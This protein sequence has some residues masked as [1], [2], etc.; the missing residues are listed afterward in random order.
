MAYELRDFVDIITAVREE[1]SIQASDTSAINRIKRDI[2]SVYIHEVIGENRW[3]W[4]EKATTLRVPAVYMG[5][6]VSVLAEED[7]VTLSDNPPTTLGSF[8]GFNFSIEGEAEIYEIT[9]HTAGDTALEISPA[10][11]GAAKPEAAFKIWKSEFSL[12]ADLRETIEIR[13]DFAIHPLEG[14]G[15][16]EFHRILQ[17]GQKTEG[18]PLYYYTGN[19]LG[20]VDETRVRRLRLFPAILNASTNVKISYVEKVEPLELDADEPKIPMQDRII[21][22]YGALVRQSMKAKDN[23]A[24]TLY[25]AKFDR[26]LAQMLGKKEDTFDKPALEPDSLYMR[27]KRGS[28]AGRLKSS[29]NMI[30]STG[31]GASA[32]IKFLSDVTISGGTLTANLAVTPGTTID[33]RDVSEDGAALDA[34]IAGTSGV[35][36]ASGSVVGTT[37]AQ[38]LINKTIDADANTISNLEHGAE[39]DDPSSGVHGVTGSVVGTTDTQ[40]LTGKTIV[41][42]DNTITTAA[43]GNLSA[44]E[45]DA[46]LQELQEDIDTRALDSD[47]TNHMSDTSTHGVGEIV[48]TTETQTLTNKT[49]QGA[50]LTGSVSGAITT[51]AATTGANQ[52]LSTP[53]TAIIRLTNASLES[54][55]GLTAPATAQFA[56]LTNATGNPIELLDETGSTAANQI[57]TGSGLDLR[58]ANAS[59]AWLYYDLTSARWR[60]V[61][62]SGGGARSV[63]GTTSS[64]IAI[65]AAGGITAVQ[66]ADEDLYLESDGGFV[67][68]TADPQI[69]AGNVAGQTLRLIGA[70]NTDAIRLEDGDGL[71]LN[72]SWDSVAGAVLSLLWDEDSTLWR[73]VSRSN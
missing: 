60:V 13:H 51:D 21:L 53:A 28:S 8:V 7:T 52:T 36:G 48:G 62:G 15:L 23:E 40:T 43:V 9:A 41:V 47:L 46:A 1:L 71:A 55:E 63:T 16:Q 20:S 12:P 33:G 2:N 34:H 19:Y 30:G 24:A 56:I 64:P 66:G 49:I 42:N 37:D 72:G 3:K 59:S 26:K 54:V 14:R 29:R 17:R 18:R 27:M 65:S 44:T 38:T 11:N 73:E 32:N 6:T 39:V 25:Q 61:G 5:G 69:S 35:H 70:S 68:V 4:L 31:G 58:L 67:D 22:V 10:F 57:L 50:L 45:L